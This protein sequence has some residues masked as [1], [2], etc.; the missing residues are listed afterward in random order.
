[1][2]VIEVV[3]VFI[4]F[5]VLISN[6]VRTLITWRELEGIGRESDVC[7]DCVH[8]CSTLALK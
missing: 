6:C 7:G 2:C 3:I 8:Y 1:M 4:F 5:N